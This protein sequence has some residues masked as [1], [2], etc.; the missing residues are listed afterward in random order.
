MNGARRG[1]RP[2][3]W[4]NL[5][6]ALV[7]IAVVG[8]LW[9]LLVR[10][11]DVK[12]FILPPPSTIVSEIRAHP[13]FYFDASMVTARHAYLG[14]LIALVVALL[15]GSLLATSRF[16]E[17]AAQPLLVLILVAPWVAYF[18]PIVT[19]LGGGDPPV[20]FLVSLVAMPA[21]V[22]ATVSGLRSADADAREL[23]ASVHASPLEVLWRLRLPSALPGLLSTARFV[24]GISLA[25][26][27]Y[28]EGGNLTVE[29]LGSIGRRAA[30]A[31]NGPLL[32]SSVFATV[33]LGVLGL[34]V[35]SLAERVLLR[36]HVS[37]R[38]R[39]WT[40]ASIAATTSQ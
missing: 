24:V 38:R 7:G 6:A 39:P 33:A 21:F 18:T 10:V 28:G 3:G 29:G 12:E 11:F 5:L 13:G 27:Y 30:A 14:M 23:L 25:A 26:A 2:S 4:L 20:L 16:L 9:E 37:Q 19:W 1:T 40:D 22:F 34:L 32:W 31:S 17:Q 15:V 8:G 36:W 35:V